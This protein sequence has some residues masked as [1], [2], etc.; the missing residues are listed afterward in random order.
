MVVLKA[1]V[2]QEIVM[3]ES[4]DLGVGPSSI[5]ILFPSLAKVLLPLESW[6]I[7]FLAKAHTIPQRK[8]HT[9]QNLRQSMASV[10]VSNDL[11]VKFQLPGTA[12]MTLTYSNTAPPTLF[13]LLPVLPSHLIQLTWKL[14]QHP[15]TPAHSVR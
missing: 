13:P 15:S 8:L 9:M 1:A 7:S 3:S 10:R 2:I 14:L 6:C 11:S 4:A 5:T 12:Q